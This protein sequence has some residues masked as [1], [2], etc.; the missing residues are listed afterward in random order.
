MIADRTP[1]PEPVLEAELRERA[2][3][4]EIPIKRANSLLA[5]DAPGARRFAQAF[6]ED[7]ARALDDADEF[8][9]PLCVRRAPQG[10]P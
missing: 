5:D 7:I 10:G 2:V 8:F 3:L 6:N 4:L 1:N 9:A